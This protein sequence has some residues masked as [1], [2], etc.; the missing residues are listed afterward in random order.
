MVAHDK[1]EEGNSCP[2]DGTIPLFHAPA[3]AS[4]WSSKDVASEIVAPAPPK[5]QTKR[6]QTQWPPCDTNYDTDTARL[7]SAQT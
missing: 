6:E 3:H 5:S 4:T 2:S 7:H 1:G